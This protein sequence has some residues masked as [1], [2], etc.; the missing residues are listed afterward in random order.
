M[1]LH[2]TTEANQAMNPGTFKSAL[3]A[4]LLVTVVLVP[5]LGKAFTMDDTVFL[6]EA[7]HALTDPLHPTAFEMTWVHAPERVSK[8]VPTGPV[9]AWLLVPSVLA[10]GSEW[11]AHAVQLVMLWVAIVA[12]VSLA[13]RL[14]LTAVWAGASGVM[15]V[16]MPAVLGMAGTAMPDVPAMALGIAGIERLAAWRDERRVGQGIAAALLLGFAPLTRLH[17]IALFG[18]A[19]LL[20][21]R[22]PF[23]PAGW[24]KTPVKRWVPLAA[25]PLIMVLLMIITHDSAPDSGNIAQAAIRYSAVKRM[26]SNIVAFSIHWVLAMAFALPWVA[27]RWRPILRRYWVVLGS[28]LGAAA[29]LHLAHGSDAPYWAAPLAGLGAAVL[30]DVL[31]DGIR[32][33]DGVQLALGLW[34]FLPLPTAIY[35]HLPAKFLVATAPAAS[36]LAARAM[37]EQ[38]RVGKAVLAVTVAL[39]MGL[40]VAILRADSAFSGLARTTSN[41]LIAPLVAQG[42]HVWYVGHWGFQWY[43]EKAGARY[44]TITPPHPAIGDLVVS[45]VNS[46]PSLEV[47]EMDG[48]VRMK[49]VEDRRPGGRIMSRKA[50]SGFFS[51]T[52]GYLP[53]AWG[54]DVIDAFDVW[55]VDPVPRLGLADRLRGS[56]P[57]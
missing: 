11:V 52:W 21:I 33:R 47:E 51:N 26:S 39:G 14:G 45:S 15:L 40:G 49:R 9:M 55:V 22:D 38:P 1:V 2:T 6:F 5:F 42:H 57:Q 10:G 17:L 53:W 18:V 16:A 32:R 4:L 46:E 50:G 37:A 7:L 12:T 28:T 20:L 29:L 35:I 3:P 48:L 23:T 19:A 34:L 36:I 8:I 30:V 43:A 13:L 56:I 54:D 41:T 24:K 27:L 44:F 25:A 31:V